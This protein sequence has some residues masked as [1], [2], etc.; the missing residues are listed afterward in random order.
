MSW[1]TMVSAAYITGFLAF[2]RLC[3]TAPVM[4]E[5]AFEHHRLSDEATDQ[6]DQDPT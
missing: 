1:A 5:D 3:S 4:P 6:S 2:C